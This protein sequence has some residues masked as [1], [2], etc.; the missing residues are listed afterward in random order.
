MYLIRIMAKQMCSSRISLRF[1]AKAST[2]TQ[3]NGC[4]SF[5]DQF[6]KDVTTQNVSPQ[7]LDT[8]A[9]AK[10]P[11]GI[12]R[13]TQSTAE[14]RCENQSSSSTRVCHS[15]LT[16]C[17]I[18]PLFRSPRIEV[19]SIFFSCFVHPLLDDLLLMGADGF[20]IGQS[21]LQHN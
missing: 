10:D 2:T 8:F 3:L 12:Q 20:P 4:D 18:M 21:R 9:P 1:S 5:A 11:V 14:S 13:C 7:P 17:Q 6:S 19:F 16:S 15:M